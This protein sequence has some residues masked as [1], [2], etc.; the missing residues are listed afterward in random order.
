MHQTLP[1]IY[2]PD[3][4]GRTCTVKNIWQK[5]VQCIDLVPLVVKSIHCTR[6]GPNFDL[7]F[8]RDFWV[9]CEGLV[10]RFPGS[11]GD[12]G[13]CNPCRPGGGGGCG[14]TAGVGVV[15]VVV[16]LL[17]VDIVVVVVAGRRCCLDCFLLLVMRLGWSVVIIVVVLIS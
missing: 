13:G 7:N 15:D 8:T 14:G 16:V 4:A 11:A 3:L 12:G 17:V 1:E 6:G 9:W 5:L 2:A 10:H